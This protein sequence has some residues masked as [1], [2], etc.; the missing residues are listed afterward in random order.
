MSRIL[1]KKV[2]TDFY[3]LSES[4]EIHKEK[5]GRRYLDRR[6]GVFFSI[7]HTENYWFCSVSDGNN[8]ID[9]ELLSR[10]ISDP[11]GMAARFLKEPEKEYVFAG[12]SSKEIRERLLYLWTRKEAYL[13]CTGEGLYGL[14]RS[15]SVVESPEGMDL[16]TCFQD[17][18]CLSICT[19]RNIL[20]DPPRQI[21]LDRES[22]R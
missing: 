15:P 17:G 11:E 8:G 21:C 16:R 13:K 4:V 7:T 22:R 5:R 10:N 20:S 2:L 19:E 1:L 14:T 12:T 9:A 6:Y 18:L 3:G